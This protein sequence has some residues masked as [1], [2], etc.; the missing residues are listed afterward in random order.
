MNMNEEIEMT[1]PD[2]HIVMEGD[3]AVEWRKVVYASDCKLCDM[4][5]EPVCA[6]C[7][8]HYADCECPGPHSDE[9]EWEFTTFF[10]EEYARPRDP[11]PQRREGDG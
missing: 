3:I 7:E 11:E 1:V 8:T 2:R 4:C 9:D 5:E 6:Y 10:G